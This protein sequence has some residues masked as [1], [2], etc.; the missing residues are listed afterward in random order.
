[1]S[2]RRPVDGRRLDADRTIRA[3]V[4]QLGFF[5]PIFKPRSA[6]TEYVFL[7]KRDARDDHARDRF[8]AIVDALRLAGVRATRYDFSHDPRILFPRDDWDWERALPFAH[9]NDRHPDARLILVSDEVS[10]LSPRRTFSRSRG[11][12]P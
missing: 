4:A 12:D 1:M 5:A 7:L 6:P 10:S 11:L 8:A 3:S 2:Q 9:L